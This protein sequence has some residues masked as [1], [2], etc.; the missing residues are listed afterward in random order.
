MSQEINR[1]GLNEIL[2]RTL[3][4][5]GA[6]APAGTLEGA[7]VPSLVLECD[8]PEWS[9]LAG[10]VRWGG[11]L[12]S[13]TLDGA[14][15]GSF[16]IVNPAASNAL[17]VIEHFWIKYTGELCIKLVTAPT[18]IAGQSAQNGMGPMDMRQLVGT[19]ATPLLYRYVA[20]TIAGVYLVHHAKINSAAGD[21]EAN[22]DMIPRGNPVILPPGSTCGIQLEGDAAGEVE[23]S[24][25]GRIRMIQT[26]EVGR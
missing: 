20:A 5:K 24:A 25:Q 13:Q 16:W 21:S 8:R 10:E 19:A 3:E 23:S 12:L 11:V 22:R 4:M 15:L 26:S 1:P 14:G 17:A 9:F 2:T 7:I 6:S 18:V